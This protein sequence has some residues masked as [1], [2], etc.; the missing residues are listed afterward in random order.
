MKKK[1]PPREN[2]C[3]KAK[4]AGIREGGEITAEEVREM[5]GGVRNS[6]PCDA[7]GY[8]LTHYRDIVRA[9]PGF[10][11]VCAAVWTEIAY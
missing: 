8:K 11:E 5:L 10:A 9:D 3:E 6:D 1:A 7:D 2:I 4:K